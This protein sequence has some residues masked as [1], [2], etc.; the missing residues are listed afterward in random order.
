MVIVPS[1]LLFTSK[2]P[3]LLLEALNDLVPVIVALPDAVHPLKV[4]T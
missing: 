1:R 2:K 4:M 3:M